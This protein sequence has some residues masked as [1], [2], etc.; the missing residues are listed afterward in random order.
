MAKIKIKLSMK[1]IVIVGLG[2]QGPKLAG[3]CLVHA[4]LLEGKYAQSRPCYGPERRAGVVTVFYRISDTPIRKKCTFME[5]DCILLMHEYLFED[6]MSSGLIAAGSVVKNGPSLLRFDDSMLRGMLYFG[7]TGVTDVK[8]RKGG[9]LIANARLNPEE[10]K[11]KA[12]IKPSRVATLDAH[13][14]SRGIY[15]DR[16]IPIVNTIMMGAFVKATNLLK[17][18]SVIDAIKHRWPEAADLNIKATLMGYEAT[19][20]VE[21]RL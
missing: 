10:I 3:D 2:G 21:I 20:V 15:G 11:F 16:P 8:L 13:A 5:A 4:A 18:N 7:G 19:K 17:L 12:D 14:I 6:F 9:V 1:E